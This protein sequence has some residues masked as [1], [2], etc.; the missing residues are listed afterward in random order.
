[1]YTVG[2]SNTITIANCTSDFAV[3]VMNATPGSSQANI[4]ALNNLYTGSTSSY[5]PNGAQTPP[6]SDYTTPTFLWSYAAGTAGIALSPVISEDGT[7]V[8]YIDTA[9]SANFN[10]LTWTT[11]QGT[12]ATHPVTPGSG[13]SLVQIAYTNS[14]V[15]GCTTKGAADSNAS[16]FVDYNTDSAYVAANNGYLYRITG[17]F[18]GTP[19][20]QYCIKV[21]TTANHLP[22]SPVYDSVNNV[23]YISDGYSLYGFTPGATGFTA[24]GSISI[25]SASA[26][27]PI[28][29]SPYLDTGNGFIYVFSAADST[30]KNA[31]VSQVNLALTSQVTAAVGPTPT[32]GY[33]LDGDFDNAYWTTGPMAGAGTLYACGTDA[34]GASKP[35]LYA[36]SFSSPSGLMNS[37]PAMS[38]N[39]N[40]NNAANS[41]GTCSPLVDVFDGTTDRLF[42][43]TG[44]Y[45][46]T[47]G[48]NLVTEW[49]V[50][51]RISSSSTTPTSTATGYWGGTSAFTPDNFSTEPQAAS[52]YFGTLQPAPAGSTTPCGTGNYCAVK[53]TQSSLQ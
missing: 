5:C 51:S 15:A 38:D 53:L 37:T 30:D 16:P 18:K 17:V 25:A 47:N 34:G 11:G 4:V 13:S 46:G 19:T 24:A 40:I 33:L 14:T 50:N 48:A 7:K 9:A 29:L 36:L 42:V 41:P 6:T 28:V 39:R 2:N 31:I 49:K 23:V 21:N 44:N 45:L 35:S 27:D 52:V 8:A 43:G 12:D 1:M 26:N 3:F 20:L 32:S 22:T 10:V